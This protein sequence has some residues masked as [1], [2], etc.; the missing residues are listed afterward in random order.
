MSM[1]NMEKSMMAMTEPASVRL[2]RRKRGAFFLKS[3]VSYWLGQCRPFSMSP[4][5]DWVKVCILANLA[6]QRYDF[7]V[8]FG[9]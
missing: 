9:K 6:L 1:N 3:I 2:S 5:G 7:I 8:R 4:T